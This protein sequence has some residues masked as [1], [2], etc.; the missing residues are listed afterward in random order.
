MLKA[1]DNLVAWAN[2][3]KNTKK[4]QGNKLKRTYEID[5]KRIIPYFFLRK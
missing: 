5:L 4:K 1:T 2:K 3:R